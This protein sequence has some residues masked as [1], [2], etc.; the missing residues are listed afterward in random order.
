MGMAW[1]LLSKQVEPRLAPFFWTGALSA[2]AKASKVGWAQ[3]AMPMSV[4]AP[5]D[6][7]ATALWSSRPMALL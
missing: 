4:T 1:L 5:A 7:C 2:S 3:A 6:Q